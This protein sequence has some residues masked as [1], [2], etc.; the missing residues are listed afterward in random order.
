STE[1]LDN[2]LVKRGSF[3]NNI[4]STIGNVIFWLGCGFVRYCM[5][6]QI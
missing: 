3:N 1:L 4:S 5:Y 2:R 6:Y